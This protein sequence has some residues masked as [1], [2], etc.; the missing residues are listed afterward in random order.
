MKL[1]P[2]LRG[3]FTECNNATLWELPAS[4]HSQGRQMNGSFTG[5]RPG[6][7][8][9]EPRVY[10]PAAQPILVPIVIPHYPLPPF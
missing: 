5:G 9:A 3:K 4:A 2:S 1:A 6:S 7:E 10:C 8:L